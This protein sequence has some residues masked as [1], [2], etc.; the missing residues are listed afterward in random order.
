MLPIF[1]LVIVVIF[2]FAA[3]AVDISHVYSDIR[4]Y[5]AVADSA[6]LAGGQ[7]LQVVGRIP[8]PADQTRARG[9]ALESAEAQLN[10]TSPSGCPVNVD[11]INCAIPGTPY[12]VSIHTP[13]PACVDCGDTRY[14]IKV[15]VENPE[16]GLSFARVFGLGQYKVTI[17]SVAGMAYGRQYAIVTLRPPKAIGATFDVKDIRLDGGTVLNVRNG[18]VGSN[19]NIEIDNSSSLNL[20]PPFAAYIWDTPK[21]WVGPPT[22]RKLNTLIP[23]PN[24]TYPAMTGARGTAPT[25]TDA[26]Q[27]SCGAAGVN[28]ACSRAD[29]NAACLTEAGKLDPARY[30]FMA[31]A[32]GFLANPSRIFCYNEGIY[33]TTNPNKLSVGSNDLAILM[34][35]V[36]YFKGGLNVGGR[37]VGGYEPGSRGVALM[38]DEAPGP[39]GA[40]ACSTC[41][42]VGN[43]ALTIALNVGS[44]FPPGSAGTAAAAAIDWNNQPVVTS[45][46]ASP[47]P[48]LLMS[49]LVKKDVG[50]PGGTQGC[51]VPAPPALLIE[52]PTCDA[53][54]NKTLKIAGG[55]A[56]ALEG[57]QYAPT[58]NVEIGGNASGFGEVGQI[59]AWTLKYSGG[60]DINQHYPGN[61]AGGVLRLDVACTTASQPCN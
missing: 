13:A 5:R 52:P 2:G 50:G 60:V 42:F 9:H 31:G 56:L 29:L 40:G 44:K 61:L 39:T 7:D 21:L 36:Y 48:P 33:D 26:R 14:A 3:L 27:A 57:V 15:T 19:A 25:F 49:L 11:V 47:S 16:F 1:A 37:I 30:A 43:S 12:L 34:P 35:G 6:S 22:D 45:G 4:L 17:A 53:D 32:T 58:D 10:A 46:P 41:D 51:Y 59:V 38:F 55:G 23:D 24:Y 54:R 20:D 28:P 8:S 18:D